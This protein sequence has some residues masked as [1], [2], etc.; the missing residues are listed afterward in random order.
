MY[1]PLTIPTQKLISVDFSKTMEK[2]PYMVVQNN[3]QLK[4][5][6]NWRFGTEQEC[7]LA[8]SLLLAIP[9]GKFEPNQFRYQFKH[10]LLLLGVTESEWCN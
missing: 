10:T 4:P 3:D 7:L 9:D 6:R 5:L 2:T 1:P 8:I